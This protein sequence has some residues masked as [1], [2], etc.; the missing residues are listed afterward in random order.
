[1][2][3]TWWQEKTI[4]WPLSRPAR[5]LKSDF[6][7]S[8]VVFFLF[9]EQESFSLC[10]FLQRGAISSASKFWVPF[11]V[12]NFKPRRRMLVQWNLCLL[13]ST[14]LYCTIGR[15]N[16]IFNFPFMIDEK[17]KLKGQDTSSNQ[18]TVDNVTCQCQIVCQHVK[19][20]FSQFLT[21]QVHGCL[22]TPA[23]TYL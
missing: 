3:R 11:W 5:I 1:M 19:F 9:K 8:K 2:G 17:L 16:H 7:T 14:C 23:Y 15:C 4:F 18:L 6:F 13:S 22:W 21:E 10:I 12:S 20:A